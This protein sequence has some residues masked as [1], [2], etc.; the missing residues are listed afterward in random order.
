VLQKSQ[1]SA[2]ISHKNIVLS[3]EINAHINLSQLHMPKAMNGYGTRE[4]IA[5]T[6]YVSLL[7][8]FPLLFL[9]V[10][11]HNH[12]MAMSRKYYKR[13][14][15]S[16]TFFAHTKFHEKMRITVRMAERQT[17]VTFCQISLSRVSTPALST[18]VISC[19][20]V[21]CRVFSALEISHQH[22]VAPEAFQ[23]WYGGRHTGHTASGATANMYLDHRTNIV[24]FQG[25]RLKVKAAGP[26]LLST[27]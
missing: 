21:H 18:L 5:S 1:R 19:R 15:V 12:V 14:S 16:Q 4:H 17:V 3:N 20:V 27:P 13:R 24:E 25:Y 7:K 8:I 9:K 23:D 10:P 26:Y 6:L 11:Y 22:A 2:V